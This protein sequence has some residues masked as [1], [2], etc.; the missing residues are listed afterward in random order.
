[1]IGTSCTLAATPLAQ[2]TDEVWRLQTQWTWAPWV[3]A[4]FAA[5][6]VA[7]V[8]ACYRYETTPASHFYRAALA[9]LRLTTVA[10]ILLMLSEAV[11]SGSRNGKPRLAILLDRSASMDREDVG[12]D[13]PPQSRL[14]AAERLLTRDDARLLQSLQ[15]GYTL[16]LAVVD[17]A[18]D[19]V[20]QGR[21]EILA[22]LSDSGGAAEPA[23]GADGERDRTATR[24]GDAIAG[25]LD[26]TPAAPLQGVLVISD[27]QVTAG[28]SLADAADAARRA[29][30]PL[31]VVGVGDDRPPPAA[32]LADL[33]ADDT[34]FVND[35]VAF[36]ATLSTQELAGKPIRVELFRSGRSEPVASETITP[37]SADATTPV[38][39]VDRP[40]EEGTYRYTLRATP[41][42]GAAD[43]V[44]QPSELSHTLTVRDEVVRVLL[45]AGY[46]NYEFR[47][48]KH[49]LERDETIR[50]AN[51]LQSADP[52][53][54]E[55]D[56]TAL[57]RMPLRLDA[58]AEYDVVVLIDLDPTL[59]P[60][61]V[62]DEL[63]R[64]VSE[65]GGGLVLV[66]GPR[67]LPSAYSSRSSFVALAPTQ[68]NQA[69]PGGYNERGGYAVTPTP[70]GLQSTAME[71][72]D[73][74]DESER[75][76]RALP[77][78]YWRA[79]V[80]PP[81]P[82]AQVLAAHPSARLDSGAPA[83]LIAEHYYG[84][85]RVLLH[86]MDSTYRWR[87]RVGDVFFARYWVQTIRSLARNKRSE[88]SAT[89]ELAAT[90]PVYEPGEAVRLRLRDERPGASREGGPTVVLQAEGRA[91]RRVELAPGAGSGRFETTLRDLPPGDYRAVLVDAGENPAAAEFKVVAPLGE[92]ARP[93]MNR[94]A[95]EA[96]AERSR[97]EFVTIDQSGRLAEIIPPGRPTALET[98]PPI[99]LWNRWP[100][101]AAITLCL[102]AEWVLRKRKAML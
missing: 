73:T 51:Y 54:A 26:A 44:A 14:A 55:A 2:A 4:L 64:F 40:T 20:A 7:A 67:S 39:L 101:L 8:I 95:L 57:P 81:K 93:E 94:A 80:G 30:A 56:L 92:D 34:A 32:R 96:A 13:G 15:E 82:A 24:L 59:L 31:Y 89:L 78:L 70:L 72:G 75:L 1:M 86:A 5:A 58:L 42:P 76:W 18:S 68:I 11:F 71:L 62:W 74:P 77:E 48:L 6:A 28:R 69:Q 65:R 49:L 63:G 90:K 83:P 99:E 50:V 84:A 60:R 46:P 98:L 23:P 38:R 52:Q 25:Q 61:S 43:R 17:A 27:G 19:R 16:E 85:G 45:A 53:Y 36:T 88:A 22:L 102:T 66:A 97:G 10:L 33:A 29:G 91:E 37:G 100:I 35:L 12:D 79:D 21:D 87:Y 47:Y 3:T 41:E 9:L